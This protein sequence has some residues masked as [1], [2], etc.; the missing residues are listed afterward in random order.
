MDWRNKVV[1]TLNSSDLHLLLVHGAWWDVKRVFLCK[2]E[3]LPLTVLALYLY[4]LLGS[5]FMYTSATS[6]F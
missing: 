3:N 6:V 5:S 4:S 2:T 1:K